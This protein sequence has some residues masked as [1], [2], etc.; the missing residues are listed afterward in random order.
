MTKQNKTIQQSQLRQDNRLWTKSFIMIT[1][2]YFLLFLSLQMLLSPFPSYAKDR[3]DPSDFMVSLTTSL[4]ALSAIATRFATAALMRKVHRNTLL[5]IGLMIATAATLAYSYVDSFA[6]LLLL[7]V[8]FGIGFGIGSTVM[9]TMV[10]QLIPGSRIGEGIGYF[11]LSTSLAMSFGPLIGLSMLEQYGFDRLT[12]LGAA[13]SILIIPLLFG[14]R[15][16]PPQ[17]MRAAHSTARDA[18]APFNRKVF[19]P[20]L[21]NVLLSVTYGGLLSFLALFGEE[22]H[23]KHVGLFFL[24]NVFS[25]LIIRPISGRLFDKHGHAAVLLPGA[26]CIVA[27]LT[28]VSYSTHLIM[29]L[30]AALLYGLGFGAMQPT[31]QAWML[32]DSAPVHH[33]AVNS[34]FYNSI[35]FGVAIGSMLLGIIASIYSYAFMYR[36]SVAFMLLFIFVY[37]LMLASNKKRRNIRPE[38]EY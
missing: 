14:S 34:L 19:F 17:P 38:L 13:A 28:L 18:K 11:G 31:L 6:T 37:G 26:I 3:F 23:L 21:L 10:T 22:E 16:I 35:D 20:A 29:L 15:S 5:L 32:R 1:L 2:S 24:F 7:R 25:I 8:C 4:F 33:G 12:F 30:A 9:P 36:C 27:G